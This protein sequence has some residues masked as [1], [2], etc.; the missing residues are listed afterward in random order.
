MNIKCTSSPLYKKSLQWCTKVWNNWWFLKFFI[1]RL[2]LKRFSWNFVDLK[3]TPDNNNRQSSMPVDIRKIRKSVISIVMHCSKP[4]F[5][6]ICQ[7]Y[8]L[9]HP[10][11]IE[12]FCEHDD[13]VRTKFPNH[14]PELRVHRFRP[15]WLRNDVGLFS[16]PAL[17]IIHLRGWL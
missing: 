16:E 8:K 4:L 14:P 2:L 15:N 11:K 5:P 17:E 10:H 3:A 7:S 6:I 13:A 12:D 9:A 1:S